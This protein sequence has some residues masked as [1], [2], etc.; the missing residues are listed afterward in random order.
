MTIKSWEFDFIRTLVRE[1]S[2]MVIDEGKE[3]IVESK[4]LAFCRRREIGSIGE[5]VGALRR[6]DHRLRDALVDHMT[7]NE[8][9]FFRDQP[10][11]EALAKD[12]LPALMERRVKTRELNIWSAAASSGQEIYS[13]AISIREHLPQLHNWRVRLLATDISTEMLDRCRA[14]TYSKLELGR[15]MPANLR[16][17]YFEPAEGG[18]FRVIKSVR[19]MV[20]LS[21]LNLSR[22]WP[23]LP[24]MDVIF[25]RNVLIYFDVAAK[26][27][28][29]GRARRILADDGFL[30][31]GGGETT[32]N[33]DDAFERVQ[34]GRSIYYRKR[35]SN[36]AATVA[37]S[38]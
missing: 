21:Q 22:A 8:T 27:E 3:Y 1:D 23:S 7:N 13:I 9:L 36:A 33:I 4:L 12:V 17:R 16:S 29:L 5:L 35:G 32:I 19:D 38:A 28:I 11:F 26:R 30:T 20:E 6:P 31:L 18:Q 25:L 37:K 10:V 14:A 34:C 2:G 24:R 15:G